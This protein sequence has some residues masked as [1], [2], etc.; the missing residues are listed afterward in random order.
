MVC[1]AGSGCEEQIF[2]WSGAYRSSVSFVKKRTRSRGEILE[3][4]PPPPPHYTNFQ[5]EWGECGGLEICVE[6]NLP[7]WNQVIFACFCPSFH[8]LPL[9]FVDTLA[10]A[11]PT[12]KLICR[13]QFLDLHHHHQ[14]TKM[15][16]TSTVAVLACVGS[17]QAFVPSALPMAR[18]R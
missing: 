12:P 13:L 2:C 1:E 7:L 4:Y 5:G 17:A 14:T 9:L 11:H 6:E 8:P 10:F 18:M 3:L 16:F 15:K